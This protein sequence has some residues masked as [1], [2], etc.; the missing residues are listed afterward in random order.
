MKQATRQTTK[1][2]NSWARWVLLLALFTASLAIQTRAVLARSSSLLSYPI[3]DLWPTAV[4]FLRID[5]G[6]AVREKDAE[7][8]YV[9][10]DLPEGG[11]TFKGSLEL[12][13]TTDGEGREATRVVVTIPDLPRHYEGVLLD[14]LAGKARDEYGSPAP[15]PPR[16]S[17][18]ES[19]RRQPPD[20][21]RP[22][23]DLPR[24]PSGELP[25]PERR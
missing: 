1:R 13:R 4:R 12:V 19:Q 9:L 23:Q 7:S 5:R 14:K 15:P 25:R 18:S 6:A 10:F 3:Q 24:M 20:A 16:R 8:G 11:K 21:G 22:I 17:P 2:T